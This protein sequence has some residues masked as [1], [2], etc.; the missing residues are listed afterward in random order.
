MARNRSAP[1]RWTQQTSPYLDNSCMAIASLT[2]QDLVRRGQRLEY[3]NRTRHAARIS[4]CSSKH[5][6]PAVAGFFDDERR[7]I[8]PG[9]AWTRTETLC[10]NQSAVRTPATEHRQVDRPFVVRRAGR[11]GIADSSQFSRSVGLESQHTTHSTSETQN[12]RASQ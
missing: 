4:K 6:F 9:S 10:R 12:N 2:R 5:L 7:T 3:F 1:A 11:I 8:P